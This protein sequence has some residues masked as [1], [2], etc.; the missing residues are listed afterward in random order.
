MRERS[1]Y[2]EG[3]YFMR[4]LRGLRGLGAVIT[5]LRMIT[6]AV[7]RGQEHQR[8]DRKLEALEN[9]AALVPLSWSL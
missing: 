7:D 8:V 1:V 9:L 4:G 3:P 5:Q 6:R 2:K